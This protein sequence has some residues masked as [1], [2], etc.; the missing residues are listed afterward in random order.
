MLRLSIGS[1]HAARC[2]PF[3]YIGF[4][5]AEH[6]AYVGQ[7]IDRRGALGR[8][9]DHVSSRED[10]SSFRR[11]LAARDDLAFDRLTDLEVLAWDLGAEAAFATIETSYREGVE[12]LVQERLWSFCGD[13]QPWLTVI[14]RVRP[15]ATT[16]AAIVQAAAARISAEFRA[17]YENPCS[18]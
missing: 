15:N 2:R 12:Y 6:V 9:V 5:R 18:P 17:E 13:L 10:V 1:T 16:A 14:S 8:W 4:S 7:T 3:V 11:R